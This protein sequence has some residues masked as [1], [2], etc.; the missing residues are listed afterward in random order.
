MLPLLLGLQLATTPY[1]P[2]WPVTLQ[3]PQWDRPAPL[4]AAGDWPQSL[5]PMVLAPRTLVHGRHPPGSAEPVDPGRRPSTIR[6]LRPA[7]PL[8]DCMLLPDIHSSSVVRGGKP[9]PMEAAFPALAST[10]PKLWQT[11]RCAG[12]GMR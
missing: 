5:L 10:P 12:E 7:Q 9:M 3:S 4:F 6:P 8:P 1:L 2:G 11:G